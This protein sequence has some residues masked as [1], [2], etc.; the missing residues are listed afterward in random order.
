MNTQATTPALDAAPTLRR[1]QVA[2]MS[3]GGRPPG[4]RPFPTA[5]APTVINRLAP[6]YHW[7]AVRIVRSRQST[8]RTEQN[9]TDHR[10][11]HHYKIDARDDA[12]LIQFR[13]SWVTPREY[14]YLSHE[15]ETILATVSFPSRS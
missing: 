12:Y 7:P 10:T 3:T 15:V 8:L 11:H 14:R 13:N 1:R 2:R 9:R 4:W 6:E 5:A